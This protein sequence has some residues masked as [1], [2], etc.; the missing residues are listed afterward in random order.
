MTDFGQNVVGM[1]LCMFI[2][3]IVVG[4]VHA[5]TDSLSQ[6]TKY[7]QDYEDKVRQTV[8][9]MVKTDALRE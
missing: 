7:T 1:L 2:I 6:R 5:C 8:R 9:E 4:G 3:W